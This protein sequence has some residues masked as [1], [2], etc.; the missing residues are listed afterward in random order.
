MDTE[1]PQEGDL[2]PRQEWRRD[3]RAFSPGDFSR[4][5]VFMED[6][7]EADKAVYEQARQSWE[8]EHGGELEEHKHHKSELDARY[9]PSRVRL[10][11]LEEQLAGTPQY[12]RYSGKDK[13]VV[14]FKDW[15]RFDL[16]LFI[17][18]GGLSL[19]A[20]V[21]GAANVYTGLMAS[22][23][24]VFI[25]AP[26][27]AVF[28]SMLVP[29]GSACIKFV[30]NFFDYAGSKKRY[31]LCV[32]LAAGLALFAWTIVFAMNFSG[33]AGDID[34]NALM[35]PGGKGGGLLV[36]LQLVAEM[37]VAAALFLAAEGIYFKYSPHAYRENLEY[38][39]LGKALK[40]HKEG[41]E[42]L[43]AMRAKTHARITELENAR[44]VFVR[45]QL[46]AFQAMRTRFNA[47]NN[48]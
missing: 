48:I 46:V 7:A 10:S 31:A 35:E 28:I 1:K 34:W 17:L 30:S 40:T 45:A 9:K 14:R 8:A 47:I 44:D 2:V 42:A 41:H 38:I 20:A 26:Y 32:Y 15:E 33:V 4:K 12:T 36:W 39:N 11:K 29:A 22:G 5:L 3:A 23:Q 43:S 27:L 13:E 25:D 6:K 16:F 37:L 18:I 19:L 21:M 24:P